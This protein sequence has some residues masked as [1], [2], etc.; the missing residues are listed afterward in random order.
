MKHKL[1]RS[2]FHALHCLL[3]VVIERP[4]PAGMSNVMFYDILKGLYKKFY[5]RAMDLKKT[6]T[7]SFTASECCAF[8][9]VFSQI[10]IKTMGGFEAN[11][12]QTICNQIN[13]RYA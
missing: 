8:Y 4:A 11:L 6:Y 1:T 13:Q 7:I 5:I 10:Q 2:E 3:K 12:I 9:F